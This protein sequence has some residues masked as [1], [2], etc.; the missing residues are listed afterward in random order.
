MSLQKAKQKLHEAFWLPE[1]KRWKRLLDALTAVFCAIS[2]CIVFYVLEF[3]SKPQPGTNILNAIALGFLLLSLPLTVLLWRESELKKI[4][5][6]ALTLFLL[7][8][9]TSLLLATFP[10]INR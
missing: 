1:Q 10:F 7:I 2:A 9:C 5:R 6:L 3:H 8:S 4:E